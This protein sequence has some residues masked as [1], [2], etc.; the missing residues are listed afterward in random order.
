MLSSSAQ[1]VLAPQIQ[2]IY[3]KMARSIGSSDP[4][5][6]SI[7]CDKKNSRTTVVNLKMAVQS[8][9]AGSRDVA[10]ERFRRLY[11]RRLVILYGMLFQA[12]YHC[13]N[14]TATITN[15]AVAEVGRPK[16][17][18]SIALHSRH[19]VAADDGSYV[20]TRLLAETPTCSTSALTPC[21][22]YLSRIAPRR[23]NSFRPGCW[24]RNCT[25]VVS[26]TSD[27]GTNWMRTRNT[28]R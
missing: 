12:C 27:S 9:A 16:P 28:T 5:V 19:T 23:W 22:V 20:Q 25:P 18:I 3:P 7:C 13:R 4:I 17:D 14:T 24:L 8:P 10:T 1:V 26:S 6:S 11:A 21:W 15:T 2:D